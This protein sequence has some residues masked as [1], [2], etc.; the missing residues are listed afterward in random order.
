MGALVGGVAFGGGLIELIAEDA[1]DQADGVAGDVAGVFGHD[2]VFGVAGFEIGD[3]I[4][5]LAEEFG[6]GRLV[7]E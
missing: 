5:P 2:L 7:V 6:V 3:D 1:A 4:E